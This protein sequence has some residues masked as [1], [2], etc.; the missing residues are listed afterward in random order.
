MSIVELLAPEG[1]DEL[2]ALRVIPLEGSLF[3]FPAFPFPLETQTLQVPALRIPV[4]PAAASAASAASGEGSA[5]EDPGPG[6][7]PDASP[8]ASPVLSPGPSP[9]VY[10]PFQSRPASG[11]GRAIQERSRALWEQGRLVEALAE[12]RRNE[13][14]HPAGL[15]MRE[16]RR[17][18][19][20]ALGL[21]AEPDEV[22]SPRVF[23]VPALVLCLFLAALS[24]TLPA[25]L[26]REAAEK[27]PGLSK[28]WL[29]RGLSLFFSVA[30][31]FCLF[32]LNSGRRPSLNYGSGSPRQALAREAPVYRVPDDLGTE[33]ARLKEGQGLLVYEIRDGWAYAESPASGHAGWIRTGSYLVY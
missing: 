28:V 11:A 10:P 32:R 12:L 27:R 15:G 13:R 23:L 8:D 31:L 22:Y 20:R 24:L 25:G 3:T 4:R 21:E 1:E 5:P 19:E 7:S 2:L 9:G 17:D 6:V 29:F 16:L 30:A 33:I 26:S 14:D 18:L